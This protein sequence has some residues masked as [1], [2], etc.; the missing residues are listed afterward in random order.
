MIGI[1]GVCWPDSFCTFPRSRSVFERSRR[2]LRSP[3]TTRLSSHVHCTSGGRTTLRWE[4]KILHAT[5]H[6]DLE[7]CVILANLE[8]R[9]SLFPYYLGFSTVLTRWKSQVR[10]PRRPLDLRR[11]CALSLHA[12]CTLRGE[13]R[14]LAR[15]CDVDIS[16]FV[17][18][19]GGTL[20]RRSSTLSPPTGR[21]EPRMTVRQAGA[22][23]SS[24]PGC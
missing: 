17:Q 6:A 15:A 22:E 20:P 9:K 8:K 16:S 18:A 3:T 14:F 19:H 23:R 10:I 13:Y 11:V 7:I 24:G 5:L 21:A 1:K 2:I 4:R 12:I